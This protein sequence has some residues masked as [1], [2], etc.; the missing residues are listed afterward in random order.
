[1]DVEQ[2]HMN[3]KGIKDPKRS[4]KKLF[5]GKNQVDAFKF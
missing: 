3:V 5:I 4:N 1:M 2:A